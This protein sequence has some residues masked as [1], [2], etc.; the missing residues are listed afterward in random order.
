MTFE[1]DGR[2]SHAGKPWWR[3]DYGFCLE[4]QRD[5]LTKRVAE[6]EGVLETAWGLIAN[7]SEGDWSKQPIEWQEAVVRWRDKDFHPIWSEVAA[8][9]ALKAKGQP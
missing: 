9:M 2:K 7:V 5:L 3:D 8:K 6:L 4:R 1:C